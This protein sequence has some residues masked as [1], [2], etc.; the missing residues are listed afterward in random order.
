MNFLLI[1]GIVVTCL[2]IGVLFS[3]IKQVRAAK[4]SDIDDESMRALLQRLAGV[5]FIGVGVAVMG[6]ML[7]VISLVF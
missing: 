7:V 1:V 4:N 5:N 3:C 2:G 6:L